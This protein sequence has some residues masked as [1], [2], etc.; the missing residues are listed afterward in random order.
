MTTCSS[1]TCLTPRPYSRSAFSIKTLIPSSP[2]PKSC[3]LGTISPIWPIIL[4]DCFTR[5]VSFSGC[6]RRTSTGWKDVC[7]Y[8]FG[9]LFLIRWINYCTL[10]RQCCCFKPSFLYLY[11]VAGIPPDMLVEA[12]GTFATAT[13]TVCRR[14][15]EGE[16]LRVSYDPN[17]NSAHLANPEIY[18]K[19]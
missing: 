6:T 12:H 8:I 2:W 1:M 4:Y 18:Q 17:T 16:E 5:R 7:V 13:C 10:L 15:Y 14:K 9:S 3:I 11:Q 19:I